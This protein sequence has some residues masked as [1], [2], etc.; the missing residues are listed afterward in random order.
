MYAD[1]KPE[2]Q[3]DLAVRRALICANVRYL[4]MVLV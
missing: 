1:E 2:D 4:R 3:A